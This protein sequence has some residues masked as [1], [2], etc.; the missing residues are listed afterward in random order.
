MKVLVI[1]PSDTKSKGGMATVIHEMRISQLLNKEFAISVYSSYIDGN[2]FTRLFYSIYAYIRFLFLYKKY[3][4]F[5]IHAA[6]YGSTF[7]KSKYLSVLKKHGK[8]IIFHIHG[9][10]YMEFYEALSDSKKN[11]VVDILKSAD[12]VVA[13]SEDWKRKFIKAFSLTNCIVLENGIDMDILKLAITDSEKTQKGFL[14]LGRLGER[15]G[16]YD[17]VEAI[18][19]A[20]QQVPDIKLY[21]AGDGEIEKF[22]RIVKDQ[23]LEDNIIIVGWASFD[24]KLDLLKKVSAVVLPSYSEGLPMAILE[25]MAC[26]KAIIST[27]VGAIPE[28][29]NKENGIL[30]DAGDIDALTNALVTLSTDIQLTKQMRKNNIQKIQDKFSVKIMHMQLRQY[31]LDCMGEKCDELL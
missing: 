18:A 3:D 5:H 11:Q 13:L 25:G 7:R 12:M 23:G 1:G 2:K 30:I 22:N 19:R 14:M 4:L 9:A 8:K 29:I 6:S 27:N 24:K 16:T 28:V 10:R 21:L 26:G 20:K 15:K 17:L 31:Y